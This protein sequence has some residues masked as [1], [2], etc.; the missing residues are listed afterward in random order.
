MLGLGFAV[1]GADK[2]LGLR[3][4]QPLFQHWGWPKSIMRLVGAGEFLGGVLVASQS[5]RRRGGML[6]A[7]T[8][9]A[10]L[11]Q[12]VQHRDTDLATPR[13]IL[14]LASLAALLV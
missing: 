8:S 11:A 12:E 13:F 1:A 6:L 14:L 9:A 3:S 10:V 7:A 2:L 4:Y 5:Q